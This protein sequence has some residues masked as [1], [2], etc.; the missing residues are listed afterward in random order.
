VGGGEVELRNMHYNACSR[1]FFAQKVHYS[2]VFGMKKNEKKRLTQSA[3]RK[4]LRKIGEERTWNT[5]AIPRT[6]RDGPYDFLLS[7]LFA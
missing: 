2:A 1:A 6:Q 4:D 5:L 3:Q 7:P